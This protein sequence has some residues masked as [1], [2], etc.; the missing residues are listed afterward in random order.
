LAG[1]RASLNAAIR[2]NRLWAAI[3]MPL[4][5]RRVPVEALGRVTA[6]RRR[7][8]NGAIHEL[9]LHEW[10]ERLRYLLVLVIFHLLRHCFH[11]RHRRESAAEPWTLPHMHSLSLTYAGSTTLAD[12]APNFSRCI[13][14]VAPNLT[15]VT[16]HHLDADPPMPTMSRRRALV[17]AALNHPRGEAGA[18]AQRDKRD[19]FDSRASLRVLTLLSGCANLRQ[20][21]LSPTFTLAAARHVEQEGIEA[22]FLRQRELEVTAPGV[23]VARLCQ[24]CASLTRLRLTLEHDFPGDHIFECIARL[25]QLR[26]LAVAGCGLMYDVP[27]NALLQLRGLRQLV[28]LDLRDGILFDPDH[29][30]RGDDGLRLFLASLPQLRVLKLQDFWWGLSP[31]GGAFTLVGK[32]CPLLTH[33]EFNADCDFRVL[34]PM[35]SCSP[36]FPVL[37]TLE[38]VDASCGSAIQA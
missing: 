34:E 35:H 22:L 4:L 37:R 25:T 23:V 36:L 11:R 21:S 2:V 7:L 27:L 18:V 38:A 9:E 10:P 33:L 28:E 15:A 24:W 6:A 26:S 32:L 20:L 12:A 30:H 16:I 14:G 31:S 29:A 3:T 5:W 17:A 13:R 19:S 1:D 8:Y